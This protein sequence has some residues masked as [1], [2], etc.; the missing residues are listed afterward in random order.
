VPGVLPVLRRTGLGVVGCEGRILALL[1]VA[2]GRLVGPE[3]LA[4]FTAA[5][6]ALVRGETSL[7]AILLAHVKQPPLPHSGFAK[8]LDAAAQGID[9]GFHPFDLLKGLN[10]LPARMG[11]EEWWKLVESCPHP[12]SVEDDLDK[13]FGHFKPDQPRAPKGTPD[14]GRWV[15]DL[16]WSFIASVEGGQRLNGYVPMRNGR[17][18]GSS[19]VTVATGIDLGKQTAEDLKK[20]GVPKELI[21]KLSPYLGK[22]FSRVKS[23]FNSQ[24]L[25]LTKEEAD[26]LDRAVKKQEL[27]KIRK[28]YNDAIDEAGKGVPFDDLPK[29]VRTII[30]ST[31][32]NMGPAYGTSRRNS[33][34]RKKIWKCFVDQDFDG[35]V[36]A[37][38]QVAHDPSENRGLRNRRAAEADY[39]QAHLHSRVKRIIIERGPI[40]T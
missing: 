25:T 33:A 13:Q 11:Y 6:D 39:L 26:I 24:G 29:E 36:D 28:T 12:M 8:A 27:D 37:L 40:A 30:A 31:A 3:V 38:R 5:S 16:D 7:A 9:G 10:L 18:I 1:S 4:K 19:S 32:Y 21:A 15:R 23:T 35:A 17:P 34:L 2:C 20:Q 14:G 22:P